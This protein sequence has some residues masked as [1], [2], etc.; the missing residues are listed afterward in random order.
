VQQHA[1]HGKL[2]KDQALSRA[3][4]VGSPREIQD[5]SMREVDCRVRRQAT[6]QGCAKNMNLIMPNSEWAEL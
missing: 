1:S 5:M 3:K 4:K 2:N 6:G